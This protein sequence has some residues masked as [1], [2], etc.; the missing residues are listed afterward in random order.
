MEDPKKMNPQSAYAVKKMLN[1]RAK[2]IS[3]PDALGKKRLK[4]FHRSRAIIARTHLK[5]YLTVVGQVFRFF[6]FV[7]SFVPFES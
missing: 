6:F 3:S 4:G 7:T 5:A 2:P 1:M